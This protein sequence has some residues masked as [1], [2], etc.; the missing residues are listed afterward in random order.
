MANADR[1]SGLAPVG[2]LN[3]APWTGGGRVYC[4]PDTDDT[5]IFA[6]GDPVTL[7][8]GADTNG[9]PTI[10]IA[11]AGTGNMVLGAIVSGAGA[12]AYGSSYGVPA[13]SPLVIPATKSRA[14]YVLVADDPN[15]IFEI[16]EVSGGTAFAAADVGL[17][18]NL[19]AGVNNG[20]L[21]GW[22]VNNAG[23]AVTSTLQLKLLQLAQRRDNAFGEHAKW[24]VLIN[25]HIYRAGSTGVS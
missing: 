22:E 6:I 2:Y 1:P 14:Y 15:T 21:S 13:E 19:V 9:I 5:N 11:T 17:N 23:A 25:N 8:G 12:L 7:A 3:G 10:T 4:I 20:Y 18:A 24:L 16:Q